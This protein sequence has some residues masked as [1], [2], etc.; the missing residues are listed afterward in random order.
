MGAGLLNLIINNGDSDKYFTG[1][2]KITFFKTIYRQHTN[3]GLETVR[4]D[5]N[6]VPL[7]GTERSVKISQNGDLIN[8]VYL[9]IELPKIKKSQPGL[10]GNSLYA[11]WINALGNHICEFI[12]IRIGGKTIDT[13]YPQ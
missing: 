8:K 9:C 4:Q 5:F 10:I 7:F 6:K 12:E 2:P 3:F 1:N 11:G 13:L